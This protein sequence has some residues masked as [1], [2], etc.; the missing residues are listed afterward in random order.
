VWIHCASV[1]ESLS[2]LALVK[3][4]TSDYRN[5]HVL[6]TTGTVTAAKILATKMPKRAIHQYV[7][8]DLAIAV[9]RFLKFWKPNL[10]LWIESELWPNLVTETEKMQIPMVLL[11]GRV[12]EKSYRIWK[13]FPDFIKKLLSPFHLCFGQSHDEVRKLRN[14]GA[15]NITYAGNLKFGAE[16]LPLNEE[17]YQSLKKNLRNRTIWLAA[18]THPDE[19]E[20]IGNIH[21]KLKSYFKNLLTI[22]VPRHPSRGDTISRTLRKSGLNVSQR[23]QHDMPKSKTEIYLAD[24]IGELSLFYKLSD[25]VFLGGSLK[26]RAGGHN[27]IEPSHFLCALIVGPGVKNFTEIFQEFFS[28]NAAIQINNHQDLFKTIL[29]LL[30]NQGKRKKIGMSANRIAENK[31]KILKDIYLLLKPFLKNTSLQKDNEIANT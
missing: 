11:N 30:K 7:P 5:L 8:I 27:P 16:K 18:S 26:D 19:E 23:S 22:I 28:N 10:A 21:I 24:T 9:R 6:I 13:I 31:S 3:K 14:L 29:S 12:S 20:I 25:V 1:G 15:K 4:I 17:K 2:T